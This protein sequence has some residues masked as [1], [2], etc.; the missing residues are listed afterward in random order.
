MATDTTL[1]RA[2][3]SQDIGMVEELIA[4][5]YDLNALFNKC[6]TQTGTEQDCARALKLRNISY[7]DIAIDSRNSEILD[8]ILSA[9]RSRTL[10]LDTHRILIKTL[11]AS[12]EI[13]KVLLRHGLDPNPI[14]EYIPSRDVSF[15]K[16]V[17]DAGGDPYA[18]INDFDDTGILL[19]QEYNNTEL[20]TLMKNYL[21]SLNALATRSIRRNK[22]NVYGLPREFLSY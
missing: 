21:P 2:I 11:D 15:Y 18:T 14:F 19:A 1:V 6:E 17:L 7:I 8:L 3:Q 4:Q 5:G 12:D 13:I 22:I 20:Y 16:M 9:Y 10:G